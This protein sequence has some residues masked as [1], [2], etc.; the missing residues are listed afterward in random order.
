[1][2]LVVFSFAFAFLFFTN[3]A[4]VTNPW[5]IGVNFAAGVYYTVVGAIT[6]WARTRL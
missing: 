2:V 3:A 4:A 6:G 1:M 5:L